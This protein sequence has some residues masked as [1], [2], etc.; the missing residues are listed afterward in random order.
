LL[1]VILV[2][3]AGCAA[4]SDERPDAR[5]GGSPD[6]AACTPAG[7]GVDCT[8]GQ[9]IC[10]RDGKTICRDGHIDCDAVP[11]EPGVEICDNGLDDD[12]DGLVDEGFSSVGMPC[13]SGMGACARTGTYICS[14]DGTALACDAIPGE[15]TQELCGNGIDDDCNGTV[16]DGF[17]NLGRDCDGRDQDLCAEG[18]WVCSDDK[19]SLVCDDTTGDSLDVCNGIDDDCDPG[20]PDGSQDPLLGQ[21]CD[22]PDADSCN[23][24][25]YVGCQDGKLV[26]SDD[27]TN[28]TTNDPKN[29]G[30]CGTGC[31]N[32]HGS[33]ACVASTCAP[34]CDT[35]FQ[36]CGDLRLG[37]TSNR[38]TNPTCPGPMLGTVAGDSGA[39]I[40]TATGYGEASYLVR[41][42]ETNV[43]DLYLSAAVGVQSPPGVGFQVC[44]ACFDCQS[45]RRLCAYNGPGGYAEVRL[46]RDDATGDQSFLMSIEVIWMEGDSTSCGDFTL[47]VGGNLLTDDRTC[48]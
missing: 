23:E 46:A 20:T 40:L 7:L 44:A 12:C 36:A 28:D 35:G 3:W 27:T 21:P 4:T 45:Q 25:V 13:T 19:L 41:V 14:K 30:A 43:S 31:E 32:P 22:G 5:P 33:S 15:P 42:A 26:C 6:A 24:G 47:L 10:A 2:A 9:G 8:S 16:D 1:L 29:C 17:D 18:K 34:T 38:D 48:N 11:G 39:Q 37:C